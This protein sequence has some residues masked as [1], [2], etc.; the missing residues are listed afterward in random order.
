MG[1]R[2]TTLALWAVLA[3]GSGC[4]SEAPI[5]GAACNAAHRCPGGLACTAGAC[6]ALESAPLSR[7]HGDEDCPVGVCLE[8]AGFCVQCVDDADCGEVAC[9]AQQ[10]VCGC[11][12]DAH[13]HTGRCDE[14]SG[15][16][17]SCLSDEQCSSGLCDV[18]DGVCARLEKPPDD[19][20]HVDDGV[21]DP[22][23]S[24]G[25]AR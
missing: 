18:D 9:I 8:G 5:E 4:V 3:A 15:V 19:D 17:L 21:P 23:G 6:S 14:G 11:R 22:K 10:F 1:R 20:E 16:C 2:A 24:A 13:C 25:G 7:C 12:E